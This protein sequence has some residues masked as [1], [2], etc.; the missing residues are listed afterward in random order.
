MTNTPGKWINLDVLPTSGH[1]GS[2]PGWISTV[3]KVFMGIFTFG[4]TNCIKNHISGR[5]YPSR[6]QI[7]PG[8]GSIL[9]Y[10]PRVDFVDHFLGEFWQLLRF[11]WAF[12]LF[13]V[14]NVLKITFLAVSTLPDDKYTREMDQSWCTSHEWTLWIISWVNF[15]SY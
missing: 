2:F 7:H 8:N 14:Q 1:C 13:G 4:G 11:L 15:D 5:I 6:W 9:M 3:I 12:S 10:F